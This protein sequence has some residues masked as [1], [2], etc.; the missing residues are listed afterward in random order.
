MQD[1]TGRLPVSEEPSIHWYSAFRSSL[2]TPSGAS[3]KAWVFFPIS[4]Y[5]TYPLLQHQGCNLHQLASTCPSPKKKIGGSRRS[6]SSAAP[7]TQQR[8]AKSKAATGPP[9]T[10]G[11]E[12]ND[13][14][15]LASPSTALSR[16]PTT[17]KGRKKKQVKEQGSSP[18]P[19]CQRALDWLKSTRQLLTF[20]FWF[21]G[22]WFESSKLVLFPISGDVLK[23]SQC[24]HASVVQRSLRQH[25]GCQWRWPPA[26]YQTTC[27]R[28]SYKEHLTTHEFWQGWVPQPT[29]PTPNKCIQ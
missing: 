23:V 13:L 20:N 9:K 26:N 19:A 18:S 8:V 27:L 24:I 12:K 28:A 1:R 14:P 3:C 2:P 10:S 29:Q 17:F 16:Y 15:L 11:E 5:F 6:T 25:P 22:I 21:F 7:T 4:P